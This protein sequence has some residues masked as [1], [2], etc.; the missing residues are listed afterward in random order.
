MSAVIWYSSC[1]VFYISNIFLRSR[2]VFTDWWPSEA[3]A[4]CGLGLSADRRPVP[5]PRTACAHRAS[6]VTTPLLAP[7]FGGVHAG[8]AKRKREHSRCACPVPSGTVLAG[9]W[10]VLE[11]QD[12]PRGTIGSCALGGHAPVI[13]PQLVRGFSFLMEAPTFCGR[14]SLVRAGKESIESCN[15]GIARDKLGTKLGVHRA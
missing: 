12:L 11:V 8:R 15:A 1:A 5:E 2:S 6:R 10:R 4:L 9:P 7:R 13:L 3:C 14:N